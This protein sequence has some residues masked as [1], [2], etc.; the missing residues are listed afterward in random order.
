VLFH[1]DA[2]QAY[3]HVPLDVG[4]DA[5]DLMSLSAHKLYGPKGIGALVVSATARSQLRP[6]ITGGDQ[7]NGLRAGTVPTPLAVGFGRAAELA[8]QEGSTH[9][10][11]IA[12]L[13]DAL[14]SSLSGRIGGI[15]LNGPRTDRLPGNLNVCIDGIDADSLLPALSDVALST[16]S[17]CSAGALSASPVLLAIGLLHAVAET[18]L[19][20]GI[21]RA[22]TAW[23]INHAAD[24]IAHVVERLRG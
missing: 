16:G 9:D 6:Q 21:G 20:F 11:R 14:L 19:R 10:A 17:A 12:A 3:G 1:T 4:R 7:Q 18:A 24:R 23:Q 5:I 15:R 2:V 8:R 22:T 13:R